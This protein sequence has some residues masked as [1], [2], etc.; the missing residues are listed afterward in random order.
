MGATKLTQRWQRRQINRSKTQWLVILVHAASG[1]LRRPTGRV[2]KET[3]CADAPFLAEIEPMESSA[4]H[5]DEITGFDCDGNHRTLAG[6][7]MEKPPALDCEAYFVLIVPV[8][9]AK[10]VEH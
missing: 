8:F 4:R 3:N 1:V 5:A 7:N 6:A 9:R 10:F 2:L